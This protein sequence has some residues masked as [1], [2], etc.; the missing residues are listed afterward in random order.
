M[1]IEILVEA[2]SFGFGRLKGNFMSW[3]SV[4]NVCYA[5]KISLG[6]K[7]GAEGSTLK[8]ESSKR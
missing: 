2:L 1:K 4:R 6:R 5:K 8:L 7:V 3:Q